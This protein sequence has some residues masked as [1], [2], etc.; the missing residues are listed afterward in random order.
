M[1]G[2]VDVVFDKFPVVGCFLDFEVRLKGSSMRGTT[3]LNSSTPLAKV[4]DRSDC[5][6]S[7]KGQYA[8]FEFS[9]DVECAGGKLSSLSAVE[10]LLRAR[11]GEAP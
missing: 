2:R 7:E 5:F 3:S 8:V 6:R 4:Q 11:E 1:A 10:S 9:E